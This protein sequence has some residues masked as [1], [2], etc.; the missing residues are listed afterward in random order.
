MNYISFLIIMLAANKVTS[1]CLSA[2]AL[3]LL[4]FV[5]SGSLEAYTEVENPICDDI[6][7]SNGYCVDATNWETQI[8]ENLNRPQYNQNGNFPREEE[9]EESAEDEFGPTP[10]QKAACDAA[11]LAV[12]SKY[13][14]TL[15]SGIGSTIATFDANS[16]IATLDV[17]DEDAQSI[18]DACAAFWV[19][20]CEAEALEDV[21][22]GDVV[23]TVEISD[24][25]EE[26]ERLARCDLYAACAEGDN[27]ECLLDIKGRVYDHFKQTNQ[28]EL[29]E[30]RDANRPKPRPPRSN[31]VAVAA[32]VNNQEFNNSVLGH[33]SAVGGYTH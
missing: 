5:S 17:S 25:D 15:A 9:S 16:V 30:I 24:E 13:Y 19:L 18:Y 28:K 29:K 26:A 12:F 32:L 2:G 3:R 31:G 33:G 22:E 6:W 14:C 10:E 11:H 7:T 21:P 8:Q 20:E 4:N 27:S 1:D 23:V